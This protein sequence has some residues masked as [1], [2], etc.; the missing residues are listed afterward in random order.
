MENPT[1]SP[2]EVNQFKNR[3]LVQAKLSDHDFFEVIRYCKKNDL[4]INRFIKLTVKT[5]LYS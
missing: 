3:N 1:K 4:N 2:A 5:F